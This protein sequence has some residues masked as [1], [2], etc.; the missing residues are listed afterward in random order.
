[1]HNILQV[2]SQEY[3]VIKIVV[4]RCHIFKAKTPQI[5]SWLTA[6]Q[7]SPIAAY[8]GPTSRE[9]KGGERRKGKG[10]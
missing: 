9:R 7:R 1:M 10:W 4:I 3:K 2:N 8:K 5:R 6:S